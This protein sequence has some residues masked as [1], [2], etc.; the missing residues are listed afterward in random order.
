MVP[1]I[2]L[3]EMGIDYERIFVDRAAGEHKRAD[4]LALNPNGRIPVLVDGQIV[5]Y[6]TAAILVHLCDTHPQA[7]LAPAV[8]TADRAHFYKWLAWM[9]NTLQASLMIYFYPERWMNPGN[10]AG[11]LELKANAQQTVGVQLD[12][13]D[14]HFAQH[15]GPWLLGGDYSALDAYAFTLCR[16]TRHFSAQPARSRAYLGPYLQ[17]MLSRPAVQRTIANEKLAHPLV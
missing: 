15:G 16:W 6:E 17:R 5:L 10:E 11:A 8:G 9:T 14:A 13:L 4:Y 12:L 3:E 1:H 7:R 2:V